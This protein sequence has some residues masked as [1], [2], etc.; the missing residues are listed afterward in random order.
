MKKQKEYQVYILECIDRTYY[1]GITK[2]FT[3]RLLKHIEGKGAKYTKG[4]GPFKV[5]GITPFT[6]K[7]NALRLEAIIKSQK[8]HNKL[9][10]LYEI[11]KRLMED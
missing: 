11:S 9:K 8:R 3:K 10:T 1:C 7:S 5:M 6:D 4:R 2:D